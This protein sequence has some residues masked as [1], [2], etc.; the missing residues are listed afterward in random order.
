MA[1]YGAGLTT[2]DICKLEVSECK[3]RL[4]KYGVSNSDTLAITGM[5]EEAYYQLGMAFASS[6]AIERL[7]DEFCPLSEKEKMARYMSLVMEERRRFEP[8]IK[9]VE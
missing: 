6:R 3:K 9:V 4:S 1:K 7:L 8:K 5:I 2:N